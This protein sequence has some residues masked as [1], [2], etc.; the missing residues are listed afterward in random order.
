MH[1]GRIRSCGY[2]PPDSGLLG[3]RTG[4]RLGRGLV[5]PKQM[6]ASPH[7]RE[8]SC[9]TCC[10]N[11]GPIWDD[12]SY[13]RAAASDSADLLCRRGRAGLA[14]GPLDHGAKFFRTNRV[15]SLL[16]ASSI[17][18]RS[19]GLGVIFALVVAVA[20]SFKKRWFC[21]YLCPTGFLLENA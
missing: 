12:V 16:S 4:C 11:R 2:H 5:H 7:E 1:L 19:V 20:S 21:L 8:R 14:V 9:K 3:D 10:T 6:Q 17:A 15:L 13:P 18:T